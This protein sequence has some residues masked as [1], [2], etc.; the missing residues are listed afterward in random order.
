MYIF[1]FACISPSGDL[2]VKE[3]DS[4]L[5]ETY[6]GPT[7]KGPYEAG[8]HSFSFVGAHERYLSV[9]VWYPATRPE[10]ANRAEYEPFSFQGEAFRDAPPARTHH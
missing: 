1:G 7:E 8:L 10:V 3:A 5:V 6:V 2:A 4:A 9:D